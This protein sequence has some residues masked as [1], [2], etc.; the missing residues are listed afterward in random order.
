M[1]YNRDVIFPQECQT[2]KNKMASE[3]RYRS[4]QFSHRE[5][6]VLK[7]MMEI[8][9][10]ELTAK[11]S[12]GGPNPQTKKKTD[13]IWADIT[14]AVNAVGNCP[15]TVAQVKEKWRNMMKKAKADYTAERVSLGKTGGGPALPEMS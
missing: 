4:K 15:R 10:G 3:K 13:K 9:H 6:E 11:H 5:T 12:S 1:Q 7:E 2:N 14:E 8:K